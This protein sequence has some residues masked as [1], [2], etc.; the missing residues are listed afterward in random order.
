MYINLYAEQSRSRMTN[1]QMAEYLKISR[2]TYEKK[3]KNGNFEVEQANK[4]CKL[5]NCK[6]EYLFATE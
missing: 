2:S 3:K 6:F 4:L 1:K 5:F